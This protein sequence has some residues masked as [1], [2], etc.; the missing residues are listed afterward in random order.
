MLQDNLD[1]RL[2]EQELAALG[3][4]AGEQ[5]LG[6]DT[7]GDERAKCGFQGLDA[8]VVAFG[9]AKQSPHQ[10][11]RPHTESV[12]CRRGRL[13][14]RRERDPVEAPLDN[15]RRRIKQG[16]RRLRVRLRKP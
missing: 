1:A 15:R 7:V 11:A 10:S 2:V 14:R 5:C 12:R 13:G 9:A 16:C 6:L 3:V 4:V 8:V